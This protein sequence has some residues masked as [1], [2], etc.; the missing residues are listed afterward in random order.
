MTETEELLVQLLKI[1]S[2]SGNEVELA[3]FLVQKL[4]NDF[5]VEKIP[6]AG[7][8]FN[9]LCRQGEAIDKLL[10][11]HIDTVTGEVPVEVTEKTITG[12][13]SCDNKGSAAAIITAALTAK[14]QGL[15]NFGLLFTI[16]EETT[17]DGAKE[18]SLFFKERNIQPRLVIIGEP[19]ELQ[20]VTA[21]YGILTVK[22]RCSGTEAHSSINNPDSAIHKLVHIL[23]NLIDQVYPDTVFHVGLISGGRASNIIAGN[24][25]ATL[26]YRSSRPNIK[27]LVIDSLAKITIPHEAIIKDLPATDHSNLGFKHNAVQYFTEMAFFANSIVLGPGSIDNAHSLNE[28]VDRGQL[29][30]A[31]LKYLNILAAS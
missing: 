11:A 12:R 5:T 6:V 27:D 22:I 8:R 26:V 25:E 19:T 7:N 14:A 16:G 15:N 30:D 10:M 18:A 28:F 21:Q 13:G 3:E 9:V 17:F 20:V 24:A 23:N 4:Q 2:T 31:S 1:P 29:N